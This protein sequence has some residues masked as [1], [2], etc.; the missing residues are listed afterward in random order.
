[1]LFLTPMPTS[2]IKKQ[3]HHP[4]SSQISSNLNENWGMWK[5]PCPCGTP[6]LPTSYQTGVPCT[7]HMPATVQK[8][9]LPL[10]LHAQ[11]VLGDLYGVF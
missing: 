5:K 2:S 6:L 9:T 11:K 7:V 10:M 8:S 4:P 1:M 3:Q